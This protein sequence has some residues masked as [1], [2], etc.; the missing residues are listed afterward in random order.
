MTYEEAR[1]LIQEHLD[2][3]GSLDSHRLAVAMSSPQSIADT[4]G[5]KTYSGFCAAFFASNRR[6]ATEQEIFD[7]G[8]RAGIARVSPSIDTAGAKPVAEV[9]KWRTLTGQTTWDIKVFDKL[10]LKNGDKL[11]AAPPAPSVADAAGASEVLSRLLALAEEN[12]PLWAYEIRDFI[13]KEQA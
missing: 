13:A 4:A 12:G 6:N 8:V 11:Y 9:I 5:A 2:Y 3:G 1:E 7:A 10:A